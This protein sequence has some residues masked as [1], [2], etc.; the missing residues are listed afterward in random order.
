MTDSTEPDYEDDAVVE[1]W[2]A[3]M[4][5]EVEHYIE[6]EGYECGEIGE[7]P[8]WQVPPYV[9][10]WAVESATEPGYV[11]AWVLCGDLPTDLIEGDDITHP[12]EAMAK[13]ADR[14]QEYVANARAGKPNDGMEIETG[15]DPEEMLDMLESRAAVLNDWALDDEMWTD[16]DEE[17]EGDA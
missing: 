2:C 17:V 10:V 5:K 1:A 13:I 4:R 15:D 6:S 8:A 11:G 9:S 14:W 12:R 16:D 7:W 3:D